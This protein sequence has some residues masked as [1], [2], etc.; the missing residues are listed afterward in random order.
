LLVE[1]GD[2]HALAVAF[3]RLL[4]NREFAV[5]MGRAARKEAEERFGLD[6]ILLQWNACMEE[7]MGP[8][9]LCA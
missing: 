1:P 5:G 2:P 9:S 3:Q 7:I 6:R 4:G 8:K